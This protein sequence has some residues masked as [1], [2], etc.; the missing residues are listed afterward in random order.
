MANCWVWVTKSWDASEA[1]FINE[2]LAGFLL[3]HRSGLES[4]EKSNILGSIRGEFSTMSVGRALREERSD[5]Q[6]EDVEVWCPRS[7]P[8]RAS[9][10]SSR[11]GGHKATL[12]E[13]RWK[14]K[15][16]NFPSKPF[17]K[18]TSNTHISASSANY[19]HKTEI[20]RGSWNSF[21]KAMRRFGG[22]PEHQGVPGHYAGGSSREWNLGAVY[23]HHWLK[24]HSL[25]VI[26]WCDWGCGQT[27]PGEPGESPVGVDLEKRPVFWFGNGISTA[28]LQVQH[29]VG[30]KQILREPWSVCT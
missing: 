28:Q 14:Q 15:Q 12:K 25:S 3:L 10:C 8:T 27:Q 18:S 7:L 5:S 6:E 1:I 24:C 30:G 26:H 2:F 29:R 13:A 11:L 17:Q 9:S 4:N 23:G 16:I 20:A 19:P 22:I 21:S